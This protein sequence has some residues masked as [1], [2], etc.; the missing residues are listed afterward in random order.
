MARRKKQVVEEEVEYGLQDEEAPVET[1]AEE[2]A[3]EELVEYAPGKGST[4][5]WLK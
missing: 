2:V 1:E 3:A 4:P 5:D